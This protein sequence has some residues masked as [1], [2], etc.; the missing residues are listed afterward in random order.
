MQCSF[1]S[2]LSF[3][4]SCSFNLPP[5]KISSSRVKS[6][7]SC[8]ILETILIS[9]C[10]KLY[11]GASLSFLITG[12]FWTFCFLPK[13]ISIPVGQGLNY[14]WESRWG[15]FTLLKSPSWLQ[16]SG[17]VK[18]AQVLK[19]SR[20]SDRS[21]FCLSEMQ[22]GKKEHFFKWILYDIWD[23]FEQYTDDNF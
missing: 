16:P 11:R 22:S 6:Q 2:A 23:G 18:V 19:S 15:A 10:R 20:K 5:G 1:Y 17:N 4:S 13:C 3:C 7:S 12:T 9:T 8:H 21:R 14:I